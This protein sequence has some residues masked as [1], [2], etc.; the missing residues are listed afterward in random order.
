MKCPYCNEEMEVG[1][2]QSR[3]NLSWN[4]KKKLVASLSFLGKDSII[5]SQDGSMFSGSD[6]IAYNCTKCEKMII[7]YHKN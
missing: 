3:D 7:D 5:L 2:I 1:Y 6:V 4:K